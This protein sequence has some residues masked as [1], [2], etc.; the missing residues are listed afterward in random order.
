MVVGNGTAAWFVVLVCMCVC[1]CVIVSG[2]PQSQTLARLTHNP[3]V[4]HPRLPSNLLMAVAL[5]VG[6]SCRFSTFSAALLL[7]MHTPAAAR[8]YHH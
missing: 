7:C 8:R 3:K 1:V 2:E 5:D 6:R 4:S